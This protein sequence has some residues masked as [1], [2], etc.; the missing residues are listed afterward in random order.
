LLKQVA[1]LIAA[2]V[3]MEMQD[4][5]GGIQTRGKQAMHELV[6]S[7]FAALEDGELTELFDALQGRLF[8]RSPQ[9]LMDVEFVDNA[10]EW[11]FKPMIEL[12]LRHI[13]QAAANEAMPTEDREDEI[14][15][16]VEMAGF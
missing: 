8:G 7:A 4:Q 5:A 14:I 10:W 3:S 13:S 15:L 6:L 2:R 12:L 9:D 11:R 1:A 16:A